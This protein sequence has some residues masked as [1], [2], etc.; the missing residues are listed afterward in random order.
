MELNGN[1][2]MQESIKESFVNSMGAE[3]AEVNP[4]DLRDNFQPVVSKTASMS[5]I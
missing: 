4:Y 1:N 5:A 2:L 3:I